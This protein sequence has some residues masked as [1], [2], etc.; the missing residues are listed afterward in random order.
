MT[1]F[2]DNDRFHLSKMRAITK[3]ALG[4]EV[5]VGLSLEDTVFYVNYGRARLSGTHNREERTRYLELNEKHERVRLAILG[6]E[7][8]LHV[9]KPEQH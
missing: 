8:Q 5:L 9:D 2:S 4:N 6:A 1:I 7:I 3:D